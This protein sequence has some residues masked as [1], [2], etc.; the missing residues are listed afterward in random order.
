MSLRSRERPRSSKY[1]TEAASADERRGEHADDHPDDDARAGAGR[2]GGALDH[3]RDDADEDVRAAAITPNTCQPLPRTSS[4]LRRSAANTPGRSSTT[5]GA[6]TDQIVSRI[7][8]GTMSRMKPITMPIAGDDADEDQL[9]E[10]RRGRAQQL[11]GAGV[12]AAVLDVGDELDDH[13]GEQRRRD[14]ARSAGDQ[15]REPGAG[16]DEQAAED[17]GEHEHD[18]RRGHQHGRLVDVDVEDPADHRAGVKPL[19]HTALELRRGSCSEP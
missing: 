18:R 16:D 5:T 14:Q 4:R 2:V 11:P 1:R 13:A 15:Q 12:A 6:A 3:E 8:P 10:H 19:S 9:P 7:S 17:A